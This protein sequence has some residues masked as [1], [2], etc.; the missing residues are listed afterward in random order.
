MAMPLL[1]IA[2]AMTAF[3][4]TVVWGPA[5][6]SCMPTGWPM[7]AHAVSHSVISEGSGMSDAMVEKSWPS[8]LP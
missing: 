8:L 4:M 6:L 7:A 1:A 2:A 3:C 5:G